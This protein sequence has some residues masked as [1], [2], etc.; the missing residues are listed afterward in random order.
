MATSLMRRPALLLALALE[1]TDA[2]LVEEDVV[3]ADGHELTGADAGVWL[4]TPTLD[5]S[6]D[7][8]SWRFEIL[9]RTPVPV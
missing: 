1:D 6:L 3:E 9:E 5:L 8:T 7:L 4:V 2:V